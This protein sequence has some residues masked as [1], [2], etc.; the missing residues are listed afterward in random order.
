MS[1][2]A[3]ASLLIDTSQD[4]HSREASWFVFLR[5]HESVLVFLVSL[6]ISLAV[7]AFVYHHGWTNL[8]GDGQ[9]HVAIARKVVDMDSTASWWERYTQLGSPWLP[10]PHLLMLPFVWNDRL[11]RT[12][13][14]GSL[15]S[16]ASFVIGAVLFFRLACLQY[17]SLGTPASDRHSQSFWAPY[18]VWM[19]YL[20]N[21]TLLYLQTTPMTEPL[22][23]LTLVGSVYFLRLWVNQ[24]SRKTL[25]MAGLCA[26]LT[27]LTRYEGWALLPITGLLVLW[28]SKKDDW[29]QRLTDG[30]VWGVAAAL[31][32]FYWFW[33]NWAIYGRVSEFYSG[34]YSASGYFVR[35]RDSLSW[36]DFAVGHPVYASLIV[37]LTVGICVGPVLLLT[38]IGGAVRALVVKEIRLKENLPAWILF[39]PPLFTAYSVY[40]GNIQ[41]YPFFLNVRYGLPA[42]LGLALFTPTFVMKTGVTGQKGKTV[43]R[44]PLVPLIILFMMLS[45]QCVYLLHNGF[46]QLSVFQE[47]YRAQFFQVAKEQKLLAQYLKAHPPTGKV[48]MHTGESAPLIIDGQLTY[49]QIIHE[50]TQSWHQLPEKI[51]DSVQVIVYREKDELDR[52]LQ[53]HPQGLEG[54]HPVWKI[55]EPALTVLSRKGT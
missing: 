33:H 6:L 50:G 4:T 16:L 35:H 54:F 42:L 8:Y 38:G 37:L 49:A 48:L 55:G 1:N 44:N 46:Q 30:V 15:V 53:N 39:I 23:L 20:C 31:G 17:R 27:T 34:V 5:R 43:K 32:P 3:E 18:L 2:T 28:L 25:A 11:W 22:F 36:L 14:A 13:L 10:L 47:A 51:P 19:A 12:G 45:L 26:T 21:P 24:G 9:A 41:I 7:L 52:L 29:K 40:S